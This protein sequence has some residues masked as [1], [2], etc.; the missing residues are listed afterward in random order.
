[1]LGALDP[2]CGGVGGGE[3]GV[4]DVLVERELAGVVLGELCCRPAWRGW[5]GAPR[6]CEGGCA[7]EHVDEAEGVGGVVR[8]EGGCEAEEADCG[9]KGGGGQRGWCVCEDEEEGGGE[10]CGVEQGQEGCYCGCW[11]SISQC[12]W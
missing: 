3:R 1:M 7:L 12:E 11:G 10:G 2:L 4:A 9:C 5:G 6:A 8:G